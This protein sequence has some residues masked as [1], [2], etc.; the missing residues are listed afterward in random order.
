MIAEK[1]LLKIVGAEGIDREPATLEEYSRDMSFAGAVRPGC[2]V[3]PRNA[4]DITAI[5]RS[6]NETQTPLVP[7]PGI[8]P[9]VRRRRY[10]RP[11]RYETHYQGRS[12]QPGG[13]VRAGRDL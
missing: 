10:R 11:E 3:R 6:A 4:A 5:V 2:V 13:H 8:A 12:D 1:R 7:V 9:E